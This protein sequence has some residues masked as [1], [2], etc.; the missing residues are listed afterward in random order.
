MHTH[1]NYH[2]PQ[3]T[4]DNRTNNMPT[5]NTASGMEAWK[6]AQLY[7]RLFL[8]YKADGMGLVDPYINQPHR[9]PGLL[10]FAPH[11]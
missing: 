6:L 10:D 8:P 4:R 5:L 2:C 11:T 1:N 9:L 7:Y 3:I